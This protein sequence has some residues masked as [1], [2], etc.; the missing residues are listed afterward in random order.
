MASAT[1]TEGGKTIPHELKTLKLKEESNF[2]NSL[3][4]IALTGNLHIPHLALITLCSTKAIL[5]S[6]T[7]DCYNTFLYRICYKII[8]HRFSVKILEIKINEI[9]CLYTKL[10][11]VIKLHDIKKII[12]YTLIQ[13]HIK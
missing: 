3:Q 10:I 2:P 5:M 9:A 12:S 1:Y 4:G 13:K 6:T 7:E 8:W 11:Y